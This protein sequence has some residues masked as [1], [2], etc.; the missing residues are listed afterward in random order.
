[1]WRLKKVWDNTIFIAATKWPA[2][3]TVM[4]VLSVLSCPVL[5]HITQNTFISLYLCQFNSDLYETLNLSSCAINQWS[6]LVYLQFGV[7]TPCLKVAILL[8]SLYHCRMNSDLYESLNL[9]S[10]ATN[11]W[12]KVDYLQFGVTAPCLEGAILVNSCISANSTLGSPRGEGPLPWCLPTASE[13]PSA[14]MSRT[15]ITCQAW[16]RAGSG[17]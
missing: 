3:G 11:Q 16:K 2:Q 7:T 8:T 13:V 1:M 15:E 6:Q 10:C 4:S 14:R 17:V 5:F 12:Y 9:S